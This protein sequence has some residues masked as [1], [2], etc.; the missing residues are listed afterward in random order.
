MSV[1][2][3]W[4]Y[5]N[6]EAEHPGLRAARCGVAIPEAKQPGYWEVARVAPVRAATP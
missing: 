6:K 2:P 1:V 4:L 5:L 3:L